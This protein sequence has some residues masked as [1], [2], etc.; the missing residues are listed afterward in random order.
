MKARINRLER[1]NREK[2]KQIERLRRSLSRAHHNLELLRQ[3]KSEQEKTGSPHFEYM[4][5]EMITRAWK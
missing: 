5:Q 4:Q 3:A 1:E 2:D